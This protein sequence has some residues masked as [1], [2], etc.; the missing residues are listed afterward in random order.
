MA[1]SPQDG[2]T[3]HM[4]R[5]FH[6]DGS[7]NRKCLGSH[8][9]REALLMTTKRR[10]Q[11]QHLICT[12]V[13]TGTCSTCRS[14]ILLAVSYGE[15]VRL[16]PVHLNLKGEMLSLL[17]GGKTFTAGDSRDGAVRLR[18]TEMITRGLPDYA[19]IHPSH[20]CWASWKDPS[21]LDRRSAQ[22]PASYSGS[23]PPF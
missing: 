22:V 13:R 14:S 20:R 12:P 1:I 15:P 3:T 23:V 21:V 5:Y 18:S 6:I 7:D 11:P 9:Q 4:N 19:W 16:D 2:Q 8:L 17:S 10:P